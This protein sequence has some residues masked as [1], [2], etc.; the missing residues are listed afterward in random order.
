MKRKTRYLEHNLYEVVSQPNASIVDLN[1][2][3]IVGM[4]DERMPRY[5]KEPNESVEND[6]Q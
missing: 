3:F 6:Y 4:S 2:T 1:E 5:F